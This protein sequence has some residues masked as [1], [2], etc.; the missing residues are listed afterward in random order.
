VSAAIG[1]LGP[2]V[3][4][5][6]NLDDLNRHAG[7]RFAVST[8]PFCVGIPQP[9]STATQREFRGRELFWPAVHSFARGAA[10]GRYRAEPGAARSG[11]EVR[12][13]LPGVGQRLMDHP[14]ISVASYLHRHA[15]ANPHSKRSF[16]TWPAVFIGPRRCAAGDMALTA[17]NKSTWHS[18]GDRIAVINI[19]VNKTF[20]EGGEVRLASADWREE[21]QVDFNLLSINAISFA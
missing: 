10:A 20:S 3:R 19:W 12:A 9:K 8:M 16:A 7:H 21:P 6:D 17:S 15:R 5:R 1:Y 4:Q 2:T 13:H 18:I 14:S 11:V